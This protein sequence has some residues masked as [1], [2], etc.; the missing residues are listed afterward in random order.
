MLDTFIMYHGN[1]TRE[2]ITPEF[3]KEWC[4]YYLPEHYKPYKLQSFRLLD[5]EC[6]TGFQVEITLD[7][8]S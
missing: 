1:K 5:C 6:H 3:V 8:S 4:D 7:R 2:E